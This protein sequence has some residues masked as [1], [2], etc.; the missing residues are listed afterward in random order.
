[1]GQL[2]GKL[3]EGCGSISPNTPPTQP[4]LS[5][6]FPC[7]RI[8]SPGSDGVL[9]PGWGFVFTTSVACCRGAACVSQ[10]TGSQ[11]DHPAGL[12]LP[13]ALSAWV[14][15]V[16]Q[17]LR[18]SVVCGAGPGLRANSELEGENALRV[19]QKVNM[20]PGLLLESSQGRWASSSLLTRGF[21]APALGCLVPA[22]SLQKDPRAWR[23]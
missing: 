16:L 7:D 9:V 11:G 22:P 3:R 10:Q 20:E 4:R 17:C 18:S 13:S 21:D 1:M 2:P 12:P 23:L 8:L 6:C 15:G 19:Q 5:F 14:A